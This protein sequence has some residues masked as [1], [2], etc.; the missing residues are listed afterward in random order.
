MVL[1]V[2]INVIALGFKVIAVVARGVAHQCCHHHLKVHV[3][4]PISIASHILPHCHAGGREFGIDR[5][6]SVAL[7]FH[8]PAISVCVRVCVRAR[9]YV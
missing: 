1:T 2:C 5:D 9:M 7:M 3:Q 8:L 6:Q 4:V